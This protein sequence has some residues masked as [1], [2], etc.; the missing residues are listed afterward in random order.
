M[1]LPGQGDK[2]PCPVLFKFEKGEAKKCTE[3]MTAI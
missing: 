2:K 1:I 3:P